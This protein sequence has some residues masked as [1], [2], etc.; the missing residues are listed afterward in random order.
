MKCYTFKVEI[1]VH[2]ISESEED[3]LAKL[4]QGQGTMDNQTK[5]LVK[6]V[7]LS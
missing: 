1:D 2:V 3:A 4:E 6:T 7:D 5:T